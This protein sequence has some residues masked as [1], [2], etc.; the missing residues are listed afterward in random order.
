MID[1]LTTLWR[2]IVDLFS[3]E[4]LT[5]ILRHP[6]L[7]PREVPLLLGI[8]V[9][10]LLVLVVVVALFFITTTD[11][12][13]PLRSVR[14]RRSLAWFF[15]LLLITL[16]SGG[17]ALAYFSSDHACA[18]CHAFAVSHESWLARTHDDIS[19]RRCH[20]DPGISGVVSQRLQMAVKVGAIYAQSPIGTF[21]CVRSSRC[22]E[23]H[24][25]IVEQTIARNR[26]HIRHAEPV[27][28]GYACTD[29]HPGRRIGNR[30]LEREYRPM[31]LCADCHDGAEADAACDT[32]HS[33]T[34]PSGPPPDLSEYGKITVILP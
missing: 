9:L 20:Q 19:C 7:H 27:A 22:L 18:S 14:L 17:V 34:S 15:A 32:C 24:D 21:P 4:K 26:L 2:L 3:R 25:D 1:R 5:D 13:K 11:R 31:A 30:R 28:A 6:E 16:A 10:I 12:P 8:S 33:A 29:C 23:C